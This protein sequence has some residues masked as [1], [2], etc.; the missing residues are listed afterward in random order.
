MTTGERA[1]RAWIPEAAAIAVLLV[2]HGASLASGQLRGDD[3]QFLREAREPIGDTLFRPWGGHV[4]PLWRLEAFAAHHLWGLNPVPYRWWLFAQVAAVCVL[5]LRVLRAWGVETPG[6]LLA[7]VLLGA[8][9]QWSQVLSGY[10]TLSISVKVWAFTLVAVLGVLHEGSGW[11]RR[12]LVAVG[13]LLAVL[14]DPAGAIVIPAVVGALLLRRPRRPAAHGDPIAGWSVAMLLIAAA[15]IAFGQVLVRASGAQIADLGALGGG[16]RT[17][18]MAFLLGPVAVGA[19]LAPS[20]AALLP[21]A[22]VPVVAWGVAAVAALAIALAWRA[23]GVRRPVIV[24][25]ALMLATGGA[26][27]AATRPYADFRFMASWTHY[28]MYVFLP[29][30]ALAGAAMDAWWSARSAPGRSGRAILALGGATILL[31]QVGGG[32]VA[33]RLRLPGAPAWEREMA[34][35]RAAAYATIADSVLRPI[36]AAVPRGANVLQLPSPFLE[37]RFPR[38]HPFFPLSFYSELGGLAA[39]QV[40]WVTPPM[41]VWVDVGL[42][43]AT[44]VADPSR[45]VDPAFIRALHAPGWLRD[46]Y[47]AAADVAAEPTL[48]VACDVARRRGGGVVGGSARARHVLFAVAAPSAEPTRLEATF[49]TSFRQ[50]AAYGV[51]LAPGASG[52]VALDLRGVPE[53]ALSDSVRLL[54]VAGARAGQVNVLG[55]FPPRN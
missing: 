21:P 31:A 6:R 11:V 23:A 53:L 48:P 52:C 1:S 19:T 43:D 46:T 12:G 27:L 25:A 50:A 15:V 38:E 9:A 28:V 34:R 16:S 37:A 32:A 42:R 10:W 33:S 44:V 8:W 20:L 40:G 7:A 4:F 36:A 47:F 41:P 2:V 49:A 18:T 13:V 3:F 55:M 39:E 26:L 29:V 45:V 22:L 35:G 30:V 24:H 17:L 54:G 5:S 14:E 51:V